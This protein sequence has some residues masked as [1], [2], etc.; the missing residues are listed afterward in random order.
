MAVLAGLEWDYCL[1]TLARLPRQKEA[2]PCSRAT[3]L[4]QSVMPGRTPG[5][6]AIIS[7][8]FEV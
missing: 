1:R 6:H 8:H 7:E 2:I 3:R 4:K 5:T